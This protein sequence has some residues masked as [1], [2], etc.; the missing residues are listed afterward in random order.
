MGPLFI[1]A[2]IEVSSI[3]NTYKLK[4]LLQGLEWQRYSEYKDTQCYKYTQMKAY[5]SAKIIAKLQKSDN[6]YSTVTF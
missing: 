3:N 1:S 2:T 4:F 5:Y 6:V